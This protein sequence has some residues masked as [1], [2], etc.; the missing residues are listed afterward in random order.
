MRFLKFSA[1]KRGTEPGGP[2]AAHHGFP[3]L[4][5]IKAALANGGSC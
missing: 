3:A 4:K 2:D 5:N 1:K